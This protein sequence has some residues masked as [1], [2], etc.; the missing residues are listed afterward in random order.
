[1]EVDDFSLCPR[2]YFR[3]ASYRV[4]MAPQSTQ[5]AHFFFYIRERSEND[6][7]EILDF[8]VFSPPP[9]EKRRGF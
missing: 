9:K 7:V 1:M 6:L 3:S 8:F 4:A 5:E 2:F